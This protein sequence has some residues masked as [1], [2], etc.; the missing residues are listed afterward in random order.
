MYF[1]DNVSGHEPSG[2]LFDNEITFVGLSS[3]IC[4]NIIFA[5][6]SASMNPFNGE[7][8]QHVFVTC[9]RPREVPHPFAEVV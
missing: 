8:N 6:P 3:E 4:S 2:K 1:F 5:V 9:P 7:L